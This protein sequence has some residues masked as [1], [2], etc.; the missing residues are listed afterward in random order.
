MKKRKL[1]M[2]AIAPLLFGAAGPALASDITEDAERA[3]RFE[4]FA[5]GTYLFGDETTVKAPPG[6]QGFRQTVDYKHFFG[7]G[8]GGG[9]NF[10]D[11]LNL[12]LALDFGNAET[13]VTT[14]GGTM[15]S[16]N[17]NYSKY[18]NSV[19][20][21]DCFTMAWDLT[22]DYNILKSRLTP[23]LE[24]GIGMR[25]IWDVPR[26]KEKYY[27]GDRYDGPDSNPVDGFFNVSG[28]GGVRWDINS[29]WFAKAIYKVGYYVALN[30]DLDGN[31]FVHGAMLSIGYKF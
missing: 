30:N 14:E 29:R 11:H 2:V 8:I 3:G 28:G 24:G 20:T 25:G 27:Y 22:L 18:G 5:E 17:G 31:L 10:S 16:P 26:V 21:R 23:V 4:V 1:C 15:Y 6:S 9:F 12:S 13:E 7:G 19:K